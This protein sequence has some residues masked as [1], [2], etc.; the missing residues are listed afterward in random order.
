LSY[1]YVAA[2]LPLLFLG[3]PPP[4]SVEEFRSRMEGLMDVEDL[5]ELDLLLDGRSGE[6]RSSFAREWHNA[7]TQLRNAVARI[8]GGH[9][10]EDVT[11]HSRAHAGFQ[12]SIEETVTRA[13]QE[14]NP[15]ETELSLDRH[16]CSVLDDLILFEPF[17]LA[18]IL[19]FALKL[20]I[21][22]RWARLSDEEG[23]RRI[24]SLVREYASPAETALGPKASPNGR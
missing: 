3:D 24:R 13:F 20:K 6:G 22:E 11:L 19:A 12:V 5:H 21:I 1:P 9:F 23:S 10:R 7:E 14:T 15:L 4:Y 18:A 16:R 2:S 8:R 17:G